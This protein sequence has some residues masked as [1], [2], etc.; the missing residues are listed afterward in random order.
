VIHFT[1]FRPLIVPWVPPPTIEAIDTVVKPCWNCSLSPEKAGTGQGDV[2]TANDKLCCGE[3]GHELA[4]AAGG[5]GARQRGGPPETVI[6]RR[7][8]LARDDRP[9]EQELL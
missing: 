1:R 5:A 2:P 3:N 8:C 7:K 6:T 9:S 4:P